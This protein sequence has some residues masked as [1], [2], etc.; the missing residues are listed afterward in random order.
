MAVLIKK[1]YK[2]F[3]FIFIFLILMSLFSFFCSGK[4]FQKEGVYYIE[5]DIEEKWNL[6]SGISFA[7]GDVLD[8][9]ISK[10]AIFKAYYYDSEIGKEVEIRP[11]YKATKD[12][13]KVY[14]NAFWVFSVIPGKIIYKASPGF[15][16]KS[17]VGGSYKLY[18]GWNAIG[19]N[20]E[21]YGKKIENIKGDCNLL[22][23]RIWDAKNQEWK[24]IELNESI[25]FKSREELVGKGISIKVSQDCNFLSNIS[26]ES[27]CGDSVCDEDE[28]E[29]SCPE[30]CYV[31]KLNN[32]S[33]NLSLYSDKELFLISDK[34]WKEILPW[35]SVSVWTGNGSENCQR[36]YG[37]SPGVCVY[38]FLIWHEDYYNYV[39]NHKILDVL[40]GNWRSKDYD[41]DE[42]ILVWT[43]NGKIYSYNLETDEKEIIDNSLNSV[44]NLKMKKGE[45]I[46]KDYNYDWVNKKNEYY[47][48]LYSLSN[49]SKELIQDTPNWIDGF[50][51]NKD[52]ISW[53]EGV[54]E[55]SSG[56]GFRVVH[57]VYLYDLDSG[58]KIKIGEE[59]ISASNIVLAGGFVVWSEYLQGRYY[60]TF[61]NISSGKI[62]K[63]EKPGFPNYLESYNDI[64]VWADWRDGKGNIFM[65]NVSLNNEIRLSNSKENERGPDIYKNKVVWSSYS[66]G[67]DIV[68]YDILN[69]QR[70]YLTFDLEDYHSPKIFEDSII[71]SNDS[72]FLIYDPDINFSYRFSSFDADSIIY[73]IQQYFPNKVTIIGD[74]PQELDNLLITEPELGAG[75]DLANIQRVDVRDYLSYWKDY[76]DIV[77]VEDDYELA[78]FASTYAS[79]INSPLIIKGSYLDNERIF[80]N[81]TKICIGGFN[82]SCDEN[83][84][85][86]Q[87]REEYI[88]QTKT[89]KFI[90]TNP[91]DLNKGIKG[92]LNPEKSSDSVYNLYSKTSLSSPILASAKN[93]L[94][95]TIDEEN[96]SDI[97]DSLDNFLEDYLGFDNDFCEGEDY[98][99][100]GFIKD[101]KNISFASN[102]VT[103]NFEIFEEDNLT[104]EQEEYLIEVYGNLFN[105][106]SERTNVDFY[107]NEDKV[108]SKEF[109]CQEISDLA[110]FSSSVW[111]DKFRYRFNQGQVNISLV[112][113]SDI[114]LN[115]L[116]RKVI[117]IVKQED[118]Y[119]DFF[120][121][122]NLLDKT[123]APETETM[124][125]D[126]YYSKNISFFE[127]DNLDINS[128]YQIFVE[129]QGR[130]VRD[131]S[132]YANDFLIG[133]FYNVYSSKKI[134]RFELPSELV[135]EDVE[136]KIV[137]NFYYYGEKFYVANVR[138]SKNYLDNYLTI[139]GAPDAI[140]YRELMDPVGGYS[141]F[142][143]LDQT[144]YA[145]IDKDLM[146]DL[147]TGRIMGITSSDFSS[148]I[149]RILF[150]DKINAKNKVSFLIGNGEDD[151]NGAFRQLGKVIHTWT[152][153]FNDSGIDVK[154]RVRNNSVVDVSQQRCFNYSGENKVKIW[155]SLLKDRE[156]TYLGH[157]GSSS[158]AGIS[159]DEIPY[160]NSSL[161]FSDSC[162][163]CAS[164]NE[165]SFCNTMI[166][167]GALAHSG[168]VCV[169]WSGNK[170]YMNTLNHIYYNNDS[171]GKSFTKSYES[172]SVRWMTNLLGDPS[173]KIN[174]ENLLNEEL[175]FYDY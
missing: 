87:L 108:N 109:S 11:D 44:M 40:D 10:N 110:L 160:L 94:I 150:Y 75:L 85:L 98:C 4:L 21:M 105:C 13:L 173:L 14:T 83:Y 45:I 134:K 92:D 77:Y 142:R 175:N 137:P 174:P 16:N 164:Y 166:R 147:S 169:A 60:L 31:F 172:N 19:I 101:S 161:V 80:E 71:F 59:R 158:F 123:C 52:Y 35:V 131:A 70:K 116:N 152:G 151:H 26:E 25:N 128:N 143:S 62:K 162:S 79:L 72:D 121:I 130:N 114:F 56:R 64:I 132:V 113:D 68:Y 69:K 50:S 3:F 66:A 99:S 115:N 89:N 112:F 165:R 33:K 91:E 88:S 153:F 61:Y 159:S 140:P 17:K 111:S 9:G 124:N 145:D 156:S 127:F 149:A 136:I 65:A 53:S 41:F 146:P 104:G 12:P 117:S 37:T 42:N 55:V 54:G 18:S 74:T 129:I 22:D 30:D 107:I 118:N 6:I 155:G 34:N 8:E 1:D 28:N 141:N 39:K 43:E 119:W 73:Y 32:N 133:K 27:Y 67:S 144:E 15:V 36:G 49:K 47:L 81:K 157:H 96:F 24:K 78:L 154:C 57:D 170:I 90:L 95:L 163:T 82:I 106:S 76:E 126:H 97:D 5:Q 125:I 7:E 38:P 100:R 138:L 120:K 171:I 168:A 102:S 58:N 20:E 84:N 135:E 167:R 103:F 2:F 148:Y 86:E 29:T 48:Y 139:I 46:L 51:I 93:E 23:S 122:C 63:V